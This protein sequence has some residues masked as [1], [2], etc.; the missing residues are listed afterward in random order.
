MTPQAGAW[1]T[2]IRGTGLEPGDKIP[3]MRL[4]AGLLTFAALASAATVPNPTPAQ[5][6]AAARRAI[7]RLQTS[8]KNWFSE[9]TCSSCHHQFLPA[10]A[11]REARQHGIQVDERIARAD[12][13]K[14][15][16]IYADLDRAVEHAHLVDPGLGDGYSL[17]A[18]DAA[19]VR[20]SV[21]TAVNA[22]FLGQR[23]KP[24][25]HW[26]EFDERPPQSYSVVTSTALAIRALQLYSHPSLKEDARGKIL[27]AREWL[28]ARTPRDT[29]ER[30]FQL[31]GLKWSE[32]DGDAIKRRAKELEGL[33]QPDGGWAS[34]DGRES[35]AYSTGEALVALDEA[36]AL[37]EGAFRRGIEYLLKTQ[38]PD[39][40]W[41]VAS[42]LYPP[43]PLSPDY[44]ESGYPYGHDQMISALGA[45]WAIMALSRA[46]GPPRRVDSPELREAK[47][48]S[49]Q[50]WVETML[51]GTG[52]DVKRLLDT[53]F[54]A[55]STTNGGT[56]ALMLAAP[57]VEKMK[58]L[59]DR[60]AKINARTK[61]GY[62]ALMMA[63]LY[64]D[65]ATALRFLLNR[66]A[67]IR[68]GS[69]E[70][71]YKAYPAALAA[72]AGNAEGVT[73]LHQAGDSVSDIYDYAGSQPGPPLNLLST[74][75]DVEVAR[76]LLD[77]GAKADVADSDGMT[78]L[79]WA[80]LANQTEMA[81]LLIE[82][83]ADVNHVDKHG[84]TPLLYAGS[85]D[86]GD[87]AMIKLL[88]DRGAKLDARS[89]DGLTALE[90]ARKYRH[91]HLL[92]ALGD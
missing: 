67:E 82:H 65:S 46:L 20:P 14:A 43:A 77:C 6:R 23:Q 56:T 13:A 3:P 36:G 18:A 7:S 37:A 10:I 38:K 75:D 35:D 53:G 30:T 8:Q 22:R 58:L 33:Q 74:F 80:A 42:R 69:G 32:A 49:V 76:A 19:G 59:L 21:V 52:E 26:N 47:P 17:V 54:D 91:T 71:L 61:N 83:G 24:D 68:Q 4:A 60:G 66:G 45:N 63:A 2:A 92:K 88:I 50:P 84:M 12:A 72:I 79:T 15:F 44:F 57:D 51:F 90:L 89:K 29:E 86:F 34:L 78:A 64:S 1:N 62:S 70:P 11:F 27:R 5:I 87:S 25:G 73:L 9:E 39:G 16:T 31:L 40:T 48:A 28:L 85:I 81:K 55:N 41:H